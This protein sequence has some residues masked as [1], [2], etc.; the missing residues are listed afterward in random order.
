M[1]SVDPAAWL[2]QPLER[3]AN[4]WPRA[5]THILVAIINRFAGLC[6][7]EIIRII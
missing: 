6:H 7:P 2:I 4:Q 5:E 1:N 3:I